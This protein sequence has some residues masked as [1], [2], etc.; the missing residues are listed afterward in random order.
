M[1]SPV[2]DLERFLVGEWR[3]SRAIVDGSGGPAG[4]FDGQ[5]RVHAEDSLLVYRERGE[6]RWGDHRGPASRCLQYRVVGPGQA[7]VF[8]DYG[9]FFHDLDLRTGYATAQHP[10]R[11]DLYRGEF[12]VVDEN[13]WWQRWVVTGPDKDHVIKTELTRQDGC[14]TPEQ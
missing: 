1:Y 12:G 2:T 13:H 10:C 5:A 3:L 14:I 11:A 7:R 9:D 8:F 4:E 6:L